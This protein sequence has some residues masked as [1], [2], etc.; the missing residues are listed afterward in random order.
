MSPPSLRTVQADF[1]HTALQSVVL[2]LRGLTRQRMGCFQ[3]IQ[4]VFGKVGI[5]PAL[6]IR[7]SATTFPA[8]PFAEDASQP[9]PYPAVQIRERR[10]V[11]VFEIL[12]P[13]TQCRIQRPDDRPKAPPS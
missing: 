1:P 10:L 3:A 11:A 8:L 13:T 5:S 4:P 12:K 9:H 7:S 2:P 6:M